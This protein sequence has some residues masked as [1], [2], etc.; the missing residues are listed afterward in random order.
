MNR[1]WKQGYFL[2]FVKK[3]QKILTFKKQLEKGKRK[4]KRNEKA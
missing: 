1:F 4:Q 3:I 2:K